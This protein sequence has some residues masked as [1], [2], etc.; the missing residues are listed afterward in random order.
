MDREVERERID[1]EIHRLEIWKQRGVKSALVTSIVQKRGKRRRQ[2]RHHLST[3]A[4]T[5]SVRSECNEFLSD[6]DRI[7][8][9]GAR[10]EP[11]STEG[12][13]LRR[14]A[15]CRVVAVCIRFLTVNMMLRCCSRSAAIAN[16]RSGPY[17]DFKLEQ[18]GS[19]D[20]QAQASRVVEHP[21][22][23]NFTINR[24][25]LYDDFSCLRR[26]RL[27][28]S[29]VSNIY[30][31]EWSVYGFFQP[32]DSR[33]WKTP[34]NGAFAVRINEVEKSLWTIVENIGSYL[35]ERGN[36]KIQYT[37][38]RFY[39]FNVCLLIWFLY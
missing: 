5:S 32:D 23:F 39:I 1:K 33:L 17:I 19:N 35:L 13:T 31:I 38:D 22:R 9:N 11:K 27:S 20:S 24:P 21:A 16:I 37:V 30:I 10:S 29:A 28:S 2:T 6:I 36:F 25:A 12:S 15:S 3:A 14:V 18:C 34:L 26:L 4:D 8:K 7:C